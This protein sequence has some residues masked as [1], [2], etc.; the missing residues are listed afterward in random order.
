MAAAPPSPVARGGGDRA[1][2]L[3]S[4]LIM[5]ALSSVVLAAVFCTLGFL[6]CGDSVY[7]L[8][9][10]VLVVVA[11]IAVV[12]TAVLA[13]AAAHG[14][15]GPSSP[16]G[17]VDGWRSVNANTP[18]SAGEPTSYKLFVCDRALSWALTAAGTIAVAAIAV[19]AMS[20]AA[21]MQPEHMD[22]QDTLGV[23]PYSAGSL[24]YIVGVGVALAGVFAL[25]FDSAHTEFSRRR[26][27]AGSLTFF[28]TLSMLL[29]VCV[30]LSVSTSLPVFVVM[31]A[32]LA[33]ANGLS[34]ALAV[35]RSML[36]SRRYTAFT[37][38]LV[39]CASCGLLYLAAFT[40]G[41]DLPPWGC[42]QGD[43]KVAGPQWSCI[44]T[45]QHSVFYMVTPPV[46]AV[47]VVFVL[48]VGLLAG[49][50]WDLPVASS[51]ERLYVY[52]PTVLP[53]YGQPLFWMTLFKVI[54]FCFFFNMLGEVINMR[55]CSTIDM[56]D[57]T[58]SHDMALDLLGTSTGV[59]F[60]V[61]IFNFSEI[62]NKGV[63]LGR[64]QPV[65]ERLLDRWFFLPW[66]TG[67]RTKTLRQFPLLRAAMMGVCTT[68]YCGLPTVIVLIVIGPQKQLPFGPHGIPWLDIV[69][70][71]WGFGWWDGNMSRWDFIWFKSTFAVGIGV[72]CVVVGYAAGTSRLLLRDITERTRRLERTP[73]VE[74]LPH[75]VHVVA[76]VFF[77]SGVVIGSVGWA[78][79]E[80]TLVG[81][82]CTYTQSV[83]LLSVGWPAVGVA[84]A[85][86]L[87]LPR[88]PRLREMWNVAMA[89]RL[90][91][92][93]SADHGALRGSPELQEEA[94]HDAT[95]SG[96][97]SP[98]NATYPQSSDNMS[99]TESIPGVNLDSLA[100][101]PFAAT[102]T[103][104]TP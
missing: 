97:A 62:C 100:Q 11:L 46:S 9:Y 80:D 104:P 78:C 47:I 101:E 23:N 42:G 29:C 68:F 99:S 43:K 41:T 102:A 51:T 81:T 52:P 37:V 53:T 8:D 65:D 50:R 40:V 21:R 49:G 28:I 32:T 79:I 91:N 64:V 66:A 69:P 88:V 39:L 92:T 73:L 33:M 35:H 34:Y 87:A 22:G 3:V 36:P 77:V 44:D 89:A 71:F 94:S 16:L 83:I 2:I 19:A 55:N 98:V 27:N 1:G 74:L 48:A 60:F 38:V 18:T 85:L 58:C 75:P 45:S 86:V 84:F 82:T 25:M 10:Q 63:M 14:V 72:I 26:R 93:S 54:F 57:W 70:R 56:W 95:G 59:G 90:P 12:A 24:H 4:K 15:S 76:A 5:G 13:V 67:R 103:P 61:T 20:T 31:V 7:D 6:L 96:R 30:C 17:S